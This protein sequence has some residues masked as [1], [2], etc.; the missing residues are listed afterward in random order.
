M[1]AIKIILAVAVIA[2]IGFFVWKYLG[3]QPPVIDSLEKTANPWVKDLKQDID[4]IVPSQVNFNKAWKSYVNI[5]TRIDD[6]YQNKRLSEVAGD[7]ASNETNKR[8]L[9]ERL[10]AVYFKKFVELTYKV[11]NGSHWKSNDLTFIGKEIEKLKKSPHFDGKDYQGNSVN[12]INAVLSKYRE[13][14]GFISTCN[15]F[16]YSYYGLSDRFPDVSDKVQKSRTYLANNLGNPYVNNCTR[17]KDG[18]RNIPQSL[19][20]AHVRYLDNKIDNWSDLYSNYS[21]QIN[22]YDSLYMPMKNEINILENDIYNVSPL[23]SEYDRLL[24]KWSADNIKAFDYP[25]PEEKQ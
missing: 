21:S 11:F 18:L 19:F 14:A 24:R 1:K 6:N 23:Q 13:I 10:Y 15:N 12:E 25:Y 16:S 9:S 8:L 22:Y 7:D 3:P 17:L 20:K 4:S 5:Q 2:V